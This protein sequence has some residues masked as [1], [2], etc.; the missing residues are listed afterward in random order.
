MDPIDKFLKL[1]S[2]KFPK[3]HIDINDSQDVL[4]MENILKEEFNILLENPELEEFFNKTNLFSD[5]G[6]LEITP[7]GIKFSE[8]PPKGSISDTLRNEVYALIKQLADNPEIED[9][10]D[11][12]RGE[13]G[14]GSSLGRAEFK[15]KG[16]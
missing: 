2:Y 11:Y 16:K 13:K 7:K 15:F 9:L 14:K 5:Y 10:T 6:T 4:L 3:G 12:K 8:I 1:Y